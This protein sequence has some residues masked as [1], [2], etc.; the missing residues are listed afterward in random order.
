MCHLLRLLRLL[1]PCRSH[2]R[3]NLPS[4]CCNA[5]LLLLLLLLLLQSMVCL[6][7]RPKLGRLQLLQVELLPLRD[8]LL[9]LVLE[10]WKGRK[11]NC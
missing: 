3:G 5:R 11:G 7:P 8:Q 4:N 10:T 2:N 1:A 9:P 6:L